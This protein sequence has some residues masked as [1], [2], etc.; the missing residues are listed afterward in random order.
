[1]D[2]TTLDEFKVSATRRDVAACNPGQ[3]GTGTRVS[4]HHQ[5]QH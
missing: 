5:P 4:P 2:L 1:M 3:V